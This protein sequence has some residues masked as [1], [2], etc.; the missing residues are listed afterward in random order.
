MRCWV[1]VVLTVLLAACSA[2]PPPRNPW[3]DHLRPSGTPLP[4]Q[5]SGSLGLALTEVPKLAA[6]ADGLTGRCRGVRT[7]NREQVSR[8]VPPGVPEEVAAAGAC[9]D[10]HGDLLVVLVKDRTPQVQRRYLDALVRNRTLWARDDRMPLFGNGF[11]LVSA[12]PAN[13]RQYLLAGLRYLRC[14]EDIGRPMVRTPA[15]LDGC[16]FADERLTQ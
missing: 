12:N 3:Y 16:V 10:G 8:L 5:G 11:L 13:P 4:K 9:Q 7:L 15:D 1:L 6:L 14:G 2:E